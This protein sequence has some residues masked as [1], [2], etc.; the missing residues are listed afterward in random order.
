[1]KKGKRNPIVSP[2]QFRLAEAVASGYQTGSKMTKKVAKELLRK[3]PKSVKRMFARH[4]ANKSV[5]EMSESFHGREPSEVIDIVEEEGYD[6]ELAVLGLLE[7]LEIL[8]DER[9]MNVIPINFKHYDHRSA[10]SRNGTKE[11]TVYC[12]TNAYGTNIE[13]VGGDQ[14]LPLEDLDLFDE[15]NKYALCI[16]KV[17]SI[18]YWTDKYHLSDGTGFS[19][20]HHEFGE[21]SSKDRKGRLPFLPTL[22][23]SPLNKKMQ[24][25]G[26]SYKVESE[27]IRD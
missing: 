26:G 20:Y 4:N 8:S 12:C 15:G 1:M 2:A 21:E 13:F 27:G 22:I 19:S 24:L 5:E 14:E 7:E 25:V 23:Y 18:T 9:G 10:F 16:G 17:F 3:T 6:N 11:E